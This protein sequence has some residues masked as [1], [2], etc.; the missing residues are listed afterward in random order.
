MHERT[1]KSIKNITH[2]DVLGVESSAQKAEL[3]KAYCNE[4][5]IWHPDRAAMWLQGDDLADAQT[6]F[7]R[8]KEAY[9]TLFDES[10]RDNY[11]FT[12]QSPRLDLSEKEK[13]EEKQFFAKR[14]TLLKK[15]Y[16]CQQETKMRESNPQSF[17]DMLLKQR[18]EMNKK[19]EEQESK[20]EE[21]ESKIA[22]QASMIQELQ[23]KI[24]RMEADSPFKTSTFQPRQ[25]PNFSASMFSTPLHTP[26]RNTKIPTPGLITI[27]KVYDLNSY[28][29]KMEWNNFA[30]V[31]AN[32]EQALEFQKAW[33]GINQDD[34]YK[35]IF[36][37][38]KNTAN[39][40]EG[41]TIL[42][43]S[44]EK[45][46]LLCDWLLSPRGEKMH[47][48]LEKYAQIENVN[49]ENRKCLNY[50]PM[51]KHELPPPKP[52]E[53]FSYSSNKRGFPF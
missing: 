13:E 43:P 38:S 32:K 40:S 27:Y 39:N 12:L 33:S 11:D 48:E 9:E 5:L 24:R 6:I 31:F 26:T 53:E 41:H 7:R 28:H 25:M 4:A 34:E 2:Y 50:A 1:H 14:N 37:I 23:A 49:Y 51:Q 30:L 35:F 3:K 42:V 46:T 18:N 16:L 22:E 36:N 17:I 19:H 8:I 45:G 47:A 21:Q 29:R 52:K 10:K 44:F 15:I 20:I